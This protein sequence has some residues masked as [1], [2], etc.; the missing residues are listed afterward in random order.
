MKVNS[1]L[2][3]HPPSWVKK[4]YIYKLCFL[5]ILHCSFIS[6]NLYT[7]GRNLVLMYIFILEILLL[8]T[9][10]PIIATKMCLK[11]EIK[12]LFIDYKSL[13]FKISY[14]KF[15]YHHGD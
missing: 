9:L 13:N 15:N 1:I 5:R 4:N 7:P 2:V 6:I 14:F 10:S 11:I 8:T 12:M 3:Q